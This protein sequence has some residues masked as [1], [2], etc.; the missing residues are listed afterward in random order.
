MNNYY[1]CFDIGG[2]S[3]KYSIY[4]AN[5]KEYENGVFEYNLLNREDIW[6]EIENIF[7]KYEYKYKN[8]KIAVSS[9]GIIDSKKKEIIGINKNFETNSFERTS[10]KIEELLSNREIKIDND[11]RSALRAETILGNAK[12]Y[13]NV[14]ML[15]VGTALGGSFMINNE[16]IYGK[17]F[18]AGEIGCGF[19]NDGFEK[20]ISELCGMY[21]LMKKYENLKNEWITA[22]EIYQN[23]ENGFEFEQ[24]LVNYQIEKIAQI[25][26]NSS[27][28]I[29]PEIVVIGGAVS[30][31]MFF[32]KKVE[33]KL[34]YFYEKAGLIKSYKITKSKFM[35]DSGKIGALLMYAN[36][37]N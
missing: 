6:K 20:N 35:N 18:L 31:N 28:I 23:A 10:L 19:L 24:S 5:I 29:D 3:L 26:F 36:E 7:Q 32:M 4:D 9:S 33:N 13:S 21:G 25:I 30:S 27:M 11:C 1:I 34:N 22:K 8:L 37:F 14:L 12:G 16:I 17:N 2:L 15:T